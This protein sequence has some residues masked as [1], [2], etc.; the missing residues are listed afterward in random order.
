MTKPMI[1][2]DR[3][4]LG[5]NGSRGR[6][7][8]R[9]RVLSVVESTNQMYSGIGRNLMETVRRMTTDFD[10]TFAIDDANQRNVEIL[11]SFAN[12]MGCE[13]HVGRAEQV[14]DACDPVNLDLPRL[15]SQPWDFVEI[16][17]WANAANHENLLR[18]IGGPLLAYTPH[19]QPSWTIPGLPQVIADRIARTQQQVLQRA[20]VVFCDSPW[21]YQMLQDRWPRHGQC[22]F[23]PL[24][25]DFATYRPG[26]LERR[27]QLLVVGD[28]VEPRKRFDLALASF[29][30]A[31]ERWPELRLLVVGNQSENSRERIP[32]SLRDACDLLGYV[33][34]SRL[35]TIYAESLALLYFSDYEAFG[36]PILEALATATPVFLSEQESTRSLFQA[37]PS[38]HFCSNDDWPATFDRVLRVLE[39]PRQAIEN[40]MESI[41]EARERFDWSRIARTKCEILRS[42]WFERQLSARPRW[43]ARTSTP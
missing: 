27:R 14:P 40:A 2:T 4:H 12:S 13:L 36:M 10:Y 8:S 20:D 28:L 19:D 34:E 9:P 21:E 42:A 41:H 15:L 16:V 7:G 35:K 1:R 37:F 23:L 11:A 3:A 18:S 26:R 31:R 32:Q 25:C 33:D 29:A 39:N 22:A 6:L 38:A 5:D 43:A 24:G 30:Q 17:G